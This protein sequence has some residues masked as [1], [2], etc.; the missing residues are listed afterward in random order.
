MLASYTFILCNVSKTAVSYWS[1]DKQ[2][3]HG[4]GRDIIWL[5]RDFSIY[6]CNLFDTGQVWRAQHDYVHSSYISLLFLLLDIF[7]VIL[8]R[9][10]KL[11]LH[12]LQLK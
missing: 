1:Y 8:S 9:H 7:L 3:M 5:Q 12:L 10:L 11:K 4:A 6:V 2:V